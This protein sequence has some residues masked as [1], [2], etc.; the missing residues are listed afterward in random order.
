M[1]RQK[2]LKNGI[3]KAALGL[4]FACLGIL[5]GVG[6]AGVTG[7]APWKTEA[8]YAAPGDSAASGQQT[9]ENGNVI[10]GTTETETGTETG[11]GTETETGENVNMENAGDEANAENADGENVGSEAGA[12]NASPENGGNEANANTENGGNAENGNTENAENS[13]N[14]E[15]ADAESGENADGAEAE[16]E[17]TKTRSCQDSLGAIGWLVCPVTG[18]LAEAVDWLYDRI[19]GILVLNPVKI[20]D[21][22]PIYEIWKYCLGLT[23]VVFVV[24][25]LIVIYSQIT[26]V[27][28]MNYGV[29][30]AL[31]KLIVTAVMVN[32]S[33]LICS[34]A[35]DAS[36]I[37]GSGLREVFQ[38]VEET[39]AQTA[40][41]GTHVGF[42]GILGA[43]GGA[44]LAVGA[45][46]IAFET[47]AIWMLIPVIFGAVVSVVIGLI[48]IAMRQAIVALLIMI[49]P[50]AIVCCILPNTEQWYRRWK[51]ALMQMLVFYPMFSLLYGASS[52]AGS[53]IIYSAKD[54]FGLIL[55][56]AVQTLPLFFSWTLMRMSGTIPGA[57]S[58]WLHG[59]AARPQGAMRDWAG[60]RREL[61]RARHLANRPILPSMR[62]MQYMSN[63]RVARDEELAQ[64]Q[65][66]VRNRGLAYRAQRNYQ[67]NG[68]PSRQGERAYAEEAQN[69]EYQRTIE[70]DRNNMNS[71]LGD[72]VEVTAKAGTWKAR[73][74]E[75]RRARATALDE[76]MTRASDYLKAE[77]TRGDQINLDNARGFQQRMAHAMDAHMDD[78]NGYEEER[79]EDGNVVRKPRASY[80]FHEGTTPADLQRYQEINRIV[81]GNAATV[82]LVAANAAQ[83]YDTQQKIVGTK[84]DKYFDTTETTKDVELRLSELT[85]S[86]H[87]V[88]NIDAIIAGMRVLNKRGDTDLLREQLQNVLDQGVQLGTHASQ[89]L[90][91]FLM[92]EVKDADPFLRRFGKYINLETAMVYSANKRKNTTVTLDE[93]VRGEYVEV[94]PATGGPAIDPD[95]GEEVVRKSKMSLSDL[96]LGTSLNGIERT[97]MRNLDDMLKHA[98]T[99]ES[100]QLNVKQ[101][102]ARRREVETSMAPALISASLNF[103]SGS[104]QMKA[105][106]SFV[107]GYD[108]NGKAR[109]EPGGDLESDAEE[110]EKYFRAQTIQYLNGQTPTQL[111]GL[112]SDY[113]TPLMEHLS[114]AYEED[115]MEGW[116]EEERAE[117]EQLVAELAEIQTRYG[118]WPAEEAKRQ[119]EADVKALK[120]QMAGSEFRHVLDAKGKLEQIYRTRRSGAANNAKDWV[121]EWLGLDDDSEIN[122]WLQKRGGEKQRQYDERH[123]E[124]APA[125]GNPPERSSGFDG[126]D[127]EYFATA[128][129]A[130]YDEWD[131]VDGTDVEEFYEQSCQFVR[132]NLRDVGELILR[133]YADYR[134]A[135]P[136]ATAQE[137]LQEL[138]ELLRDPGNY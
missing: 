105:L 32:L 3:R 80:R 73:R 9:D 82:Q 62:L 23:N 41:M 34:V 121:R 56:V 97:A 60:Q 11:T 6:L 2:R 47:G 33:F 117:R 31:P 94:D 1:T 125:D 75:A 118:D 52:L 53:A 15:D 81:D 19:E 126:A 124:A 91:N 29:K 17:E 57:V 27:G 10:E 44:G 69:L 79:D 50:L 64:H 49:S 45:G 24:F 134:A 59:L 114:R 16:G 133:R 107:T 68:A 42:S 84:M 112:R 40:N 61:S 138:Q 116:S 110:A 89:A 67:R 137:L 65:Q 127:R 55:G 48:T 72:R 109:W 132:D 92:F 93:M 38:S 123:E 101:Y 71:G 115:D 96:M 51:H 13:E 88:E 103:L 7:G 30:R 108:K 120:N 76:R 12:E 90:G 86:E 46:V 8:A 37:I 74:Q 78:V 129:Q 122:A 26:G 66:T 25:F 77:Q 14:T 43:L 54:G 22:S 28:I 58:S 131:G 20:E 113:Y 98:Y 100:G 21:G 83:A 111:L 39:M 99:D 5:T 130:V 87:A 35:V 36:N 70:R 95:T 135:R 119:R 18:K 106:V 136:R 85:K 4:V 63:R 104:E 102:L 128:L